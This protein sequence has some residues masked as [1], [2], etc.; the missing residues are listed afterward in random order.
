MLDGSEARAT[1]EFRAATPMAFDAAGLD[2]SPLLADGRSCTWCGKA[3]DK[4]RKL[5]TSTTAAICN[6][7]VSLCAEILT[8]E[9]GDDWM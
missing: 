6:E 7:C 3:Q 5:L 8:A 4:V 9:L 1:G 2:A